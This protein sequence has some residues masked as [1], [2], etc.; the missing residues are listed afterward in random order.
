MDNFSQGI[1]SP[2]AEREFTSPSS[3]KR[4]RTECA[5]TKDFTG[6][7]RD[8]S[9]EPL[10][11]VNCLS[12]ID[13]QKSDSL[14]CKEECGH[15]QEKNPHDQ[16]QDTKSNITP[17]TY[18]TTSR[19][20]Q[21]H[22]GALAICFISA[23]RHPVLL[24]RNEQTLVV[25]EGKPELCLRDDKGWSPN[26]ASTYTA[27]FSDCRQLGKLLKDETPGSCSLSGGNNEDGTQVQSHASQIQAVTFSTSQRDC[28]YD[29]SVEEK[30][31]CN[32]SNQFVAVVDTNQKGGELENVLFNKS[33]TSSR[34][35]A[36]S[37]PLY[38]NIDEDPSEN[39]E[40]VGNN[41]KEKLEVQIFKDENIPLCDGERKGQVTGSE[42]LASAAECVE[43]SILF[44]DVVLD[45]KLAAKNVNLEVNNCS[46][47]DCTEKTPVAA[48]ISQEPAEGA[49]DGNLFSVIDPAIRV[50]VDQEIEGMLCN[51]DSTAVMKLS[52]SAKVCKTETHFLLCSD[53]E[54]SQR[55][56]CPGKTEQSSSQS[57]TEQSKDK[58]EYLCQS[59][60]EPEACSIP[61]NET[62]EKDENGGN[63]HRKSSPSISP[64]KI[65][66]DGDRATQESHDA[67]GCQ[68]KEQSQS[69]CFPVSHDH[70][71]SQGVEY[72]QGETDRVEETI[73]ING[74]EEVRY[75]LKE[76]ESEEQENVKKAVKSEEKLV[77]QNE[78]DKANASA[79]D[80]IG[81]QG[82]GE[83]QNCDSRFKHIDAEPE[84]KVEHLC[85]QLSDADIDMMD[86]AT[87]EKE[88]NEEIRFG[89]EMKTDVYEN[90]EKQVKS[91][92]D[93]QKQ[94][95]DKE[96]VSENQHCKDICEM[97]ERSRITF[98]YVYDQ[99]KSFS[100]FSGPQHRAH[101]PIS[102]IEDN[103]LAFSLPSTS[104]AVVPCQLDIIHSQNTHHNS[105]A[106][107][108]QNKFTPS[109]FTLYSHVL[110]GFDTFEKIHLS[111][112]DDDEDDA[113]GLGIM[114]V[115]TSLPTQ[116][117]KTPQLQLQ[118]C[119]PL[120][121]SHSHKEIPGK[122]EEAEEK[123]ERC[124]ENSGSGFVSSDFRCN[125]CPNFNPA[126]DV[127]ALRQ[128]EEQPNC[129]PV[130]DLSEQTHTELSPESVSSAV[131]TDSHSPSS[132]LN[133][134][135]EFE[136]KEQ[137]D[138]V[139]T[140]LNLF[141]DI[142]RRDFASDCRPSPPDQ[143]DIIA[144][145][146]EGSASKCTE[147]LSCP[148]LENHKSTSA[149]NHTQ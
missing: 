105:T 137:F 103:F 16:P 36:D 116:L 18:I 68:L 109:A 85:D 97:T 76:T 6:N 78:Q 25:Q 57:K 86:V 49:R 47:A 149:G 134:C 146:M 73:E 91:Q 7:N 43:E 4:P 53:V 147:Y 142:S 34:E 17:D 42:I 5:V 104:D 100:C 84:N 119:M 117:L 64:T 52:Q 22:T 48:R 140:E 51:T 102:E 30:G 110:A 120:A 40:E 128:P 54:A 95:E 89:E 94:N 148:D 55:V 115:L 3:P 15:F 127:I 77:Q 26:S 106:L 126:V 138:R 58:N 79:C 123:F 60:T 63:C 139:L 92:E 107:K 131:A 72:S 111:P 28:I 69:S 118:H 80:C 61:S 13:L 27:S 8:A 37:K 113:S 29:G 39:F 46:E 19:M 31:L 9:S 87:D 67:E 33:P 96:D 125:E 50:E 133:N 62:H 11:T 144:E 44:Y 83:T 24:G 35:F 112:D 59:H 14:D 10:K 12:S 81:D 136:M 88:G 23:E 108:C 2:Q 65:P 70:T 130:C 93:V 122:E 98:C 32:T 101:E 41:E 74:R 99:E 56:S 145:L 124:T 20:N 82:E 121:E 141:F 114:P 21:A 1:I 132:G 71:S 135:C 129:A 90:S 38:I 66:F 143:C 75:F 45:G